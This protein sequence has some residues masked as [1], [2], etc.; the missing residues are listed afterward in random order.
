MCAKQKLIHKDFGNNLN[1]RID[2]RRILSDYTMHGHDF[3]EIQIYLGGTTTEIINGEKYI[4]T[5]GSV[6][7]LTPEDLHECRD[8]V[9]E[10]LYNIQFEESAVSQKILEE[11]AQSENKFVQIE[12]WRFEEEMT[13]LCKIL[14]KSFTVAKSKEYNSRILDCILLLIQH[15]MKLEG[16]DAK[17]KNSNIQDAIMY[18]RTHFKENPTLSEIADKV[19]LN[20]RYFCTKFKEYTGKSYKEYLKE[21]KLKYAKNIL[22]TTNIPIIEVATQSGY[23]SQ[24]HFNREFKSFYGLSPLE[25]RK[26]YK[27]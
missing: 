23:G 7:F 1:I 10:E 20:E 9:D 15:D 17:H 22:T 25:M 16:N 4:A 5:R 6:V 11:L 21:V 3:Y 26:G 2:R 8:F 13:E 14:E 19:H 24:S 27:I 12:N 18:I